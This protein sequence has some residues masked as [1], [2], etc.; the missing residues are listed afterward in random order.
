MTTQQETAERVGA[1]KTLGLARYVQMVFVAFW[2]ILLF[3]FD[4]A[5]T[6]VWDNFAEPMPLLS[7]AGAAVLSG[8]VTIALYKNEKISRVSNDVV[9]E[10]AKVSWPSREETQVS[11]VV[12]IITS[13][14]A[15][16]I[17]GSFDAVWS[18]ITDLIYKV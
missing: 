11:T 13:I 15:A 7:T 9:G 3:I 12:V 16:I 10:L 6:A 5:I 14:I 4:K 18:A 17:V 2:A 8:V 1:A